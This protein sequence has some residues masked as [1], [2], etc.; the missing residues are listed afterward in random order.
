[1]SPENLNPCE[2]EQ[3]VRVVDFAETGCWCCTATRALLVGVWFGVSLG[4]YLGGSRHAGLIF[5][6]AGGAVVVVALKVARKVWASSYAKD[7]GEAK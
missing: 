1:M 6:L 4:L 5:L 2:R 3:Y 7:E